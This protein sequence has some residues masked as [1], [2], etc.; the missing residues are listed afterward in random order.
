MDC[1]RVGR[2]CG[3]GGRKVEE[4]C[5][6]GQE[7]R[8]ARDK[9]AEVWDCWM[10]SNNALAVLARGGPEARCRVLGF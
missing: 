4:V 1:V 6:E 9:R 10:G 3:K 8:S 5:K 2:R 7:K